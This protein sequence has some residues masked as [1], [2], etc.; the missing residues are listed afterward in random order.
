[1]WF[2]LAGAWPD[3]HWTL[4]EFTPGYT[5]LGWNDQ[6]PLDMFW[7][8][9][10]EVTLKYSL[11]IPTGLALL[12]LPAIHPREREG[13]LLV[14]GVVV[15]QL[16][17]VAMQ[18][19]FF[20]YHYGATVPL[21]AWIAAIGWFKVWRYAKGPLV[22]GWAI[23]V[24]LLHFDRTP[25]HDV[26]GDYWERSTKR[27]A[28][29]VGLGEF[30]SKRM[31]DASLYEAADSHLGAN[32]D[33]ADR[34]RELTRPDERVFIWGFEPSIYF[35]SERETPTR[36]VYNVPQ[37]VT[38][39][40]DKSRDVLLEELESRPQWIVVQHHD[41]FPFVTGDVLDSERS[42]ETFPA[43]SEILKRE[44]EHAERIQDFDLYRHSGGVAVVN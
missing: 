35:L 25:I 43:L 36:F 6:A 19:K 34:L 18:A 14:L 37:R 26:P 2:V 32:R 23:A 44:Y 39:E 33:V 4:F 30:D 41:V 22:W 20:P 13:T 24:C 1:V 5:A 29:L 11:L 3:L 38:W 9:V 15:M 17:G 7:Y 42:L 12:A 28:W 21:L 16:C 27:L 40:R 8:A 31:L 10:K